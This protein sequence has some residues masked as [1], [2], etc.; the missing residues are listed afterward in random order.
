MENM[1]S[2]LLKE[3]LEFINVPFSTISNGDRAKQM[4]LI[5]LETDLTIETEFRKFLSQDENEK[6]DI[7]LLNTR[8][9][10][11]DKVTASNLSLM[12]NRFSESLNL[13]PNNYEFDVIG[14]GCTSA[15]LLIG[16]EKITKL[17]QSKVLTD[18]V[19]T[20]MLAVKKALKALGTNKIGYIAPYIS[21]IAHKMCFHLS[22]AGFE[23]VKAATFAEDRDS[24]VGVIT[25][26]SIFN[27]I[28]TLIDQ[29]DNVEAIF[30]SC[31]SLKCASIISLAEEKFGL[32]ILS[33]NSVLAWDMMKLSNAT[34]SKQGKGKLFNF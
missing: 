15:S 7:S 14:Y 11:D 23:V 8:I 21:E 10:C 17:V 30:I 3:K 25:P 12:E 19:T 18:N 6:K 16:D 29:S 20:P 26:K 1:M 22:Q 28:E 5:I 32:P 34:V 2:T 27:A 24:V 33:S 4:G 13:F 9:P 31:T